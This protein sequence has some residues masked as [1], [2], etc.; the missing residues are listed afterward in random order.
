MADSAFQIAY[1]NEFINGFEQSQALI[2]DTVTNEAVI[3]GNQATFLVAD[4]GGAEA[5]TRGLNGRIPSRS[6]NLNQYVATLQDW[7]DVPERNNFNIFASQGDG[8]TLMQ[9][10][11]MKVI[12][13][14]IDQDIISQLNTAT[15]TTGPAVSA[16]VQLCT[17][18]LTILG[19]N[20]VNYDGNIWALISPGFLGFLLQQKEFTSAEYV[21]SRPLDGASPQAKGQGYY[22]WNMVKWIVHN[23]LP[24]NGTAAE[25]CFMYH[26][27]AI[28]HAVDKS[29]I[30]SFVGYDE[31]HDLSWARCT[32]YMGS[33]LLQ[34]SGVVVI[35]HN[36]SGFSSV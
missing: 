19:N 9:K 34:N 33:K 10:T 7:H 17:H 1:R 5:V 11:C 13:R 27:D 21:T 26:K 35:N 15:Q 23:Q 25:K 22:E 4:S 3:K 36:A 2:R 30:Q 28:G 32:V 20:D 24:G 31:K 18:A 8:K 12:N 16:S 29:G 6:D 14:R